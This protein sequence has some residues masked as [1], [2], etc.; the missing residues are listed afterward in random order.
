MLGERAARLATLLVAMWPNFI[1]STSGASKEL[2]LTAMLSATI[3]L[4]VRSWRYTATATVIAA[5]ALSGL[6]LGIASL[7]QPSMLLFPFAMAVASLAL[8]KQFRPLTMRLTAIVVAM[9][10]VI[11]PWSIR[12]YWVIDE[13]VVISTNGGDV[14]YRANN[15][16]ATGGYIERGEKDLWEL[17]VGEVE[18]SRIGYELGK[19]WIR[20][21]PDAFLALAMKKQILFLGDDAI[22]AYES[23]KRARDSNTLAYIGAKA[24]SNAFWILLWLTI[25][26][27]WYARKDVFGDPR[28]AIM[29]LAVLY[30]FAIDSVFESGGRHHVPLMGVLAVLATIIIAPTRGR[31]HD[32]EAAAERG[33]PDS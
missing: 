25:L 17:D 14:F 22:G 4:F 20:Q 32:L 30:L 9:A 8:T 11:A 7:A 31:D 21:N 3:W 28:I 5:S 16:L 15:P 6:M 19:T 18:R 24:V 10:A 12:N 29:P 33:H 13:F 27:G 26:A 23:L 2:L 1:F